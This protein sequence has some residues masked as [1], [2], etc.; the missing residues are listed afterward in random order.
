MK[1]VQ[2]WGKNWICSLFVPQWAKRGRQQ[3]KKKRTLDSV[4]NLRFRFFFFRSKQFFFFL[5]RWDQD[6]RKWALFFKNPD[7]MT[8][9]L[10]GA[11]MCLFLEIQ[12]LKALHA[13]CFI[14]KCFTLLVLALSDFSSDAPWVL[15]SVVS[16]PPRCPAAA[17]AAVLVATQTQS[18]YTQPLSQYAASVKTRVSHIIMH[19]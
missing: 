9:T 7:G 12:S 4:C 15:L 5:G 8:F 13:F 3:I 18:P 10:L 2:R 11:K 19:M 6:W 17:S 16:D 1:D 14:S